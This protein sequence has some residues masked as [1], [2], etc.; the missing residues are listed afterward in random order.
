MAIGMV[1]FKE[2]FK[3]LK[4]AS[5]NYFDSRIGI[6]L[7]DFKK[8]SIFAMNNLI[9]FNEYEINIHLGWDNQ[10]QIENIIKLRISGILFYVSNDIYLL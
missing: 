2:L 6:N 8:F 1:P 10:P 3:V 9:S 4:I 5:E 7:W